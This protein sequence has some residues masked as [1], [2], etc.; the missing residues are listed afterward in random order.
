MIH[1]DIKPDNIL[2][3]GEGNVLLADFGIA[4]LVGGDTRLT[5]TGGLVGTPAYIAPEQG[6]GLPITPSADIYSLG[7]V[8]YE[9]ITGKQPYAAET[10][11]QVVLK[12]MTEP[13]PSITAAMEGL[14]LVLENVMQRVLAKNPADRYETVSAFAQD[15]TRVLRSTEAGLS[16]PPA[17]LRPTADDRAGTINFTLPSNATQMPGSQTLTPAPTVVMQMGNNSV[18]LLGGLGLIA[19]LIVTIAVLVIVALDTDED[20]VTPTAVI[21]VENTPAVVPTVAPNFGSL[22]FSSVNAI[23]DTVN[24]RVQRFAPTAPGEQYLVW[25]RNTATGDTLQLGTLN[26][27]AL[28]S[29]VLSYTDPDGRLLPSVAN[30]V[31]ITRQAAA[32]EP[33]SDVVYS[34][35]VPLEVAQALNEIL[36]ASDEGSGGGS[37]LASVTTEAEIG[38]QHAGLAASAG[39]LGG[40]QTHA[41]HTINILQGGETDYNGDGRGEN[42]GRSKLGLP[43]YLDLIEARLDTAITAPGT[44]T[45]LQAEAE[46]IRVCLDNVRFWVAEVTGLEQEAIAAATIE[47]AADQVNEAQMLADHIIAG[48]DLNENNLIDP[49]EGECGL[50]QIENFSVLVGGMSILEGAVVE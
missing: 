3:D 42:P 25:L 16:L 31:L 35:S 33:T 48:D 40:M 1:R 24:L 20:V 38:A 36:V 11:M 37:L 28:G 10:P 6:Q 46:L 7:V 32:D 43:Y 44:T 9:M 50:S 17:M 19:L 21:A 2:I 26:T 41:E 23:G 18:L 4:K 45:Q 49:F 22:T 12:H 13:V 8:V 15:F 39:S 29:G 30:A 47:A 14:P 34:G 27:D 5:A